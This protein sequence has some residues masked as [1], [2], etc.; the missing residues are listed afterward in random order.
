MY[1]IYLIN[2]IIS[3]RVC[4]IPIM[5]NINMAGILG[6]VMSGGLRFNSPQTVLSYMEAYIV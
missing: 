3:Y 1:C 5:L 2:C 4:D 6:L